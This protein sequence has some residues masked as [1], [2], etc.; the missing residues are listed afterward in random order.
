MAEEASANR[1]ANGTGVAGVAVGGGATATGGVGRAGHDATPRLQGGG[2]VRGLGAPGA[3]E[4]WRRV[5]MVGREKA[6]LSMV[7][8]RGTLR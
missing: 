3:E 5:R 6:K 8:V 2:T 1:E 7:G 4:P